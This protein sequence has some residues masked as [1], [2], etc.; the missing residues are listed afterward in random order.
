MPC[1]LTLGFVYCLYATPYFSHFLVQ[2]FI[3]EKKKE[4]EK[5]S[6]VLFVPPLTAAAVGMLLTAA[7]SVL[8]KIIKYTVTIK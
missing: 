2:L 8:L 1:F 3:K 7:T 5:G 6:L 4:M